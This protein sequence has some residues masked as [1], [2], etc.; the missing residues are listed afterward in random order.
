MY[1]VQPDAQLS[2]C[3][4]TLIFPSGDQAACQQFVRT[5]LLLQPETMAHSARFHLQ[6]S[7][8]SINPQLASLLS[9]KTTAP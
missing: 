1:Q 9:S 2:C 4:A 3:T 6:L 8:S 5:R 7:R